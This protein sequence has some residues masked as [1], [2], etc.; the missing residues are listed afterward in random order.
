LYLCA[1]VVRAAGDH[2]A[3]DHIVERGVES[4]QSDR[5]VFPRIRRRSRLFPPD[6]QQQK[7]RNAMKAIAMKASLAATAALL[8]STATVV[9]EDSKMQPGQPTTGDSGKSTN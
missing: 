9:A 7:W 3:G 8:L 6:K 1:G 5:E 4:A 2:K